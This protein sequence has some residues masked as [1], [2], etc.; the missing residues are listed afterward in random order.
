MT[1]KITA[2][3]LAAW[4]ERFRRDPMNALRENALADTD[5]K[6]VAIDRQKLLENQPCF[7]DEVKSGT[8]LAQSK[9]G[10]CWLFAALNTLRVKAIARHGLKPGFAFSAN[11]LAFWDKLERANWF[12]EEIIRHIGEVPL[13]DRARALLRAPIQEGGQWFMACD[14]IDKYGLVPNELMPDTF[15]G[16]DSGNLNQCLSFQ[17]RMAAAELR[18]MH[19]EGRGEDALRARKEAFLQGIYQILRCALGAPPASF[20]YAYYDAKG[21]YRRLPEQTPQEF[22]RFMTGTDLRD[23]VCVANA[24]TAT[25]PFH[26]TFTIRDSGNVVGTGGALYY[27]LEMPVIK[28]LLV[29]QLQDG[30]SV[31]FGCDCMK[32]MDRQKGV[33]SR[34]LYRYE[35]LFGLPFEMDK[36]DML[37]Y[38]H[39]QPNHNMAIVGVDIVDGAPRRWKV[40]NSWG[41]QVGQAGFYTMDDGFLEQYAFLFVIEKKYLTGAQLEEL[42]QEPI[43][44][45]PW[46]PLGA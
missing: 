6:Q 41:S 4:E 33:M 34:E 13:G 32:M 2:K 5:I 40:E 43:V 35:S 23:Y 19:E 15:A 30:Q 45:E 29:R 3:E 27:N 10:R 18:R 26:R 42:T 22:Y 25:H 14:L 12:L 31:W 20:S 38:F 21:D 9:T 11:Y 37:S 7:S 39:S 44:L 8:I 16:A 17:L 28:E 24:P 46:D 1:E 36:G